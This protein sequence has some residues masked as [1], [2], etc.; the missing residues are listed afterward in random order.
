MQVTARC[1]Q[2]WCCTPLDSARS[3]S[4]TSCRHRGCPLTRATYQTIDRSLAGSANAF[5]TELRD[6]FG[7]RFVSSIWPREATAEERC[8]L[9]VAALEAGAEGE[10][11]LSCETDSDA[12]D[13]LDWVGGGGELGSFIG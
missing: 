5:V 4:S 2:R 7:D 1:C 6:R 3:P 10:D 8:W 11:G 9:R 12:E 13:G